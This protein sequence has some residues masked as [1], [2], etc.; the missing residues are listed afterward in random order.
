MFAIYMHGVCRKGS[1]VCVGPSKEIGAIELALRNCS[2]RSTNT[3]FFGRPYLPD[4]TRLR[5][6]TSSITCTHGNCF[7]AFLVHDQL[8]ER[9]SVLVISGSRVPDGGMDRHEFY[10][11]CSEFSFGLLHMHDTI[12]FFSSGCWLEVLEWLCEIWFQRQWSSFT[13]PTTMVA[14]WGR[15]VPRHLHAAAPVSLLATAGLIRYYRVSQQVQIIW[16]CKNVVFEKV[17][18]VMCIFCVFFKSSG[19]HELLRL[20][21]YYEKVH[22][23]GRSMRANREGRRT[24]PGVATIVNRWRKKVTIEAM[25]RSP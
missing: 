5:R 6:H 14:L 25:R 21:Y 20:S 22:L 13:S 19:H 23:R 7:R 3:Y 11:C 15:R 16:T 18:C 1:D 12:S 4:L 9:R 17:K 2:G 10:F 8:N 24:T